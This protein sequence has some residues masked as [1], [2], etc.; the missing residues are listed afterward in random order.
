MLLRDSTVALT[1]NNS[2][3]QASTLRYSIGTWQEFTITYDSINTLADLYL[4]GILA[5]SAHFAVEHGYDGFDRTFTIQ[6]NAF[7]ST[8][9][10]TLKD[11]RIY[12]TA[13]VPT[14][15]QD[16]S[17]LLPE[18]I[19]LAQNYP[20]PFNPSTTIRYKL[21][22]PSAVRIVITNAL[23]QEVAMLT[24]GEKEAGYHELEWRATVA[25]GVYF[26]RIDAVSS[27]DPNNRIV[28]MKKMLLLK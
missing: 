19:Q 10:G 28:R 4:N 18:N 3:R 1:Y 21:Q 17:S 27:T 11:L 5:C 26:Y 13:S 22:S 16:V 7:F 25:S 6:N 24:D 12:S 14:T 15:V 2:K 9:R 8:F 23:G 20:N